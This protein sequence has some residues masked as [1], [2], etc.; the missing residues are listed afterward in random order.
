MRWET[1][2]H[3]FKAPPTQ[4]MPAIP[5]TDAARAIEEWCRAHRSR[6]VSPYQTPCWCDRFENCR[7]CIINFANNQQLPE[8]PRQKK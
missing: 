3:D 4:R 7:D 2:D 6:R 8:E 5:L 1:F